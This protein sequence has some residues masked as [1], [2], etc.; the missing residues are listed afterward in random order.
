MVLE[1]LDEVMPPTIEGGAVLII[2]HSSP[3]YE[4]LMLIVGL[5]L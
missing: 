1:L 2:K 5:P 3:D 4:L